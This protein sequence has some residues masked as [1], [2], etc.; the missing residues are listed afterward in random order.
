MKQRTGLR[1]K[2]S[3]GNVVAT[4]ALF[5]AL[6][7][8][9]MAASHLG[10]NSVGAKQLKSNAV[11]T[12][13]IKKEAVTRKKIKK[14]AVNASKVADHSLTGTQINLSAL[15]TVPSAETANTANTANSLSGFK[16][17]SG[18]GADESVTILLST[19][20]FD[21]VGLCDPAGTLVAPGFD[22]GYNPGGGNALGIVNRG[23]NG[24]YTDSTDDEDEDFNIGEGVAFD[25]NDVND[26]G[27]AV[28][29]NGHFI[30]VLGGVVF[31]STEN[32]NFGPGCTFRGMAW[33]G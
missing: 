30:E 27:S 3:Y 5:L 17:F 19:G 16:V 1:S 10:K 20:Q 26:G 29:P 11:T 8:G 15:G 12:A 32:P 6:G 18:R 2:L 9:A 28:L 21:V 31:D 24:G 13:K 4:L 33:F 23:Q 14:G 7:G 22:N 25:Y